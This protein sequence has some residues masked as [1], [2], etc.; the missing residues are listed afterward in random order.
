MPRRGRP[1]EPA[2]VVYTIAALAHARN[3][4]EAALAAQIDENAVRFFVQELP[5]PDTH[6]LGEFYARVDRDLNGDG[7]NPDY[8][9]ENDV[10]HVWEH[11]YLY[12]AAMVAFGSR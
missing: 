5:T 1:N 6:H 7:V 8:W 11:A 10:P 12:A 9:S 2:N 3:E 4:D